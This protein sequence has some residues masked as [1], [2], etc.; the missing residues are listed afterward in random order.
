MIGIIRTASGNPGHILLPAPNGIRSKSLPRKSNPD[1]KNLCGL[2]SS[3]S[4]HTVGSR[5][6]A[7]AFTSTCVPFGMVYPLSCTSFTTFRGISKGTG[8]CNRKVSFT[9]HDK[10]GSLKTSFSFTIL[11]LPITSSSSSLALLMVSGLR[12][13]STIAHSNVFEV[14]SV[15]APNKSYIKKLISS[16][17]IIFK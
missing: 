17:S 8:G 10:Y 15:P 5:P 9:M 16:I 13:T 1:F 11:A 4:S 6:M 14:V 2:N 3:E 12:S 7:Q